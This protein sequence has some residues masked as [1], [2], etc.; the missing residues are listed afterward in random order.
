MICLFD[1]FSYEMGVSPHESPY[2]PRA[3]SAARG[4]YGDECGETPSRMKNYQM[5]I[6]SHDTP[7]KPHFLQETQM[8]A[9]CCQ[10]W[11]ISFQQAISLSSKSLHQ[12]FFSR[13]RS[14]DLGDVYQW[15]GRSNLRNIILKNRCHQEYTSNGQISYITNYYDVISL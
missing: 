7:N 6:F 10:C 13:A 8:N 9:C 3:A 11:Q 15:N 1:C 5:S 2:P 12:N 14:R 4:G